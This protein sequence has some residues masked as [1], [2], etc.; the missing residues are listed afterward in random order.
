M[1][2]WK[3]K[4]L[5]QF[6]FFRGELRGLFLIIKNLHHEKNYKNENKNIMK[7]IKIFFTLLACMSL[8]GNVSVAQE[9]WDIVNKDMGTWNDKYD[10]VNA[11]NSYAWGTVPVGGSPSGDPQATKDAFAAFR[12]Q[13][14]GFVRLQKPSLAASGQGNTSFFINPNVQNVKSG[15]FHD[16]V[17]DKSCTIELKIQVN[18]NGGTTDANEIR[19]R[20]S[21][22]Q[23]DFFISYGDGVTGYVGKATGGQDYSI[24]PA[25]PHIYRIEYDNT[26]NTTYSLYVDDQ[27]AFSEATTSNTGANILVIG[28]TNIK[29]CNMDLYYVR[30]KTAGSSTWDLLNKY[31]DQ[32]NG[33]NGGL[34]ALNVSDWTVTQAASIAS[35]T[36]ASDAG[37]DYVNISKSSTDGAAYFA[38]PETDRAKIGEE[39]IVNTEACTIE[40]KARIPENSTDDG[41]VIKLRLFDKIVG[42]VLSDGQ[43]A[44]GVK[45]ATETGLVAGT[46]TKSLTTSDWNTYTLVMSDDQT[47]YS[48]YVN[49]EAAF[50]DL[51]TLDYEAGDSYIR[52]GGET[53][54]TCDMD[55]ASVKMGTGDFMSEEDTP[56]SLPA[57][58]S[59]SNTLSVYPS[60]ARK[61]ELLTLS[62]KD[63][64]SLSVEIINITGSRISYA[65]FAGSS[66]KIQAP[67]VPGV[68]LVKVNQTGMAKILV[69]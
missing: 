14:P 25:V 63:A 53:F 35:V 3:N 27:F 23:M 16:A 57:A 15:T 64:G 60:I 9:S 19:P 47:T 41:N 28:A 10:E 12:T 40:V 54:S 13:F 55:V 50:E 4:R 69:K 61:G 22:R 26:A 5:P 68:Y 66:G 65:S 18:D 52:L 37:V 49:G 34:N 17:Q 2:C 46:E 7:T 24:N 36:K 42:I 48:V 58:V 32:W 44:N 59:G 51:P 67:A 38:T 62:A 45:H 11:F 39:D 31:M 21:G 43:I 20:L 30:M 33:D 6:P 1:P 8:T 56:T 29:T